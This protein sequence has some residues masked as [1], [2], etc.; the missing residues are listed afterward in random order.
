NSQIPA[1]RNLQKSHHG[2]G[3]CD[4]GDDG[5]DVFILTRE[6]YQGGPCV[7]SLERL[8]TSSPSS[9]SS[10][11]QPCAPR[12]TNLKTVPAGISE[13]AGIRH[14]WHSGISALLRSGSGANRKTRPRSAP[15]FPQIP[16]CG[17]LRDLRQPVHEVREVRDRH[18][19]LPAPGRKEL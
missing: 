14:S 19:A 3:G 2:H 11:F 18:C 8:E 12:R 10:H 7:F 13:F 5:D 17:R 16:L 1:R 4:D 6:E 9:P 15:H